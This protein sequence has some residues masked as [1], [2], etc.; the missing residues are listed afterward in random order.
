MPHAPSPEIADRPRCHHHRAVK[1]VTSR[2][3]RSLR[4][5]QPPGILLDVRTPDEFARDHIAGALHACV[6]EIGFVDA[7]RR[8]VP[9]AGTPIVV[10]GAGPGSLESTDAARRLTEAGFQ[11]VGNF[12]GGLAEWKGDGLPT[13]GEAPRVQ[14]V[15]NGTLPIDLAETRIR[16]VGRNLL[17]R[18]EGTVALKSGTLVFAEGWL[19][20]GEFVIDMTSIRCSDLADSDQNRLLIVH[21]ASADFFDVARHPEAR[22]TLKKVAPVPNGRPGAPNLQL[23]CD[24]QLRG[25]TRELGVVAIA[26]RTP[27]GRPAA[28]AVL[29]FDRTEW[30]SAYG[31]G[32]FFQNL[33]RHLVN[34][35]VEIEVRLV[36]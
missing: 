27:E 36:V 7:V 28:Q 31:S 4:D 12:V 30:G 18:H 22:L 29:T 14:A 35:L 17:N 15:P 23:L 32:R 13:L 24:F 8:L 19:T 5:A 21:L 34:D 1:F 33:G 3:V 2:D 6:F 10:C 16:W 25:I 9:D 26:G 11:E 20:G